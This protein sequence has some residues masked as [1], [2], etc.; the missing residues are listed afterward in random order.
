MTSRQPSPY[1]EGRHVDHELLL[2][3]GT[4][5]V[6]LSRERLQTLLDVARR[7]DRARE[8]QR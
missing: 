6:A 4:I 7:L 5:A 8:D 1:S 2:E 3:L